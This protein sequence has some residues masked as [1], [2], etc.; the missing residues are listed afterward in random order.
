MTENKDKIVLQRI[1]EAIEQLENKQ[2]NFYFFVSDCKNTPNSNTLYIYQM[3]LTLKER[4]YN[5]TMLYQL[6]NEYTPNELKQLKQ[7][8]KPIDE[9]RVFTGVGEWLGEKY[10]KLPHLNIASGKWRVS[11]ADF[12]FI[13]EVFSS[14]MKETFDKSIPCKRYVI[15]Q[16]FKYVTEFIPFGDQWA[17]YGITD[18]IATTDTL[19]EQIKTVFPYVKT[20]VL[21]PFISSFIRKP[22]TAKKLIVNIAAPR[23][24]EI[25]HIIKTFYWR[26]PTLQFVTYADMLRE[27][28]ITVWYD[29]ESPFGYSG[30][31]AIR[32]GNILIGKIPET[33]PEWMLNEDKLLDNGIWYNNIDEIPDILAKVV[34][35]WMRDE[36]PEELTNAME[37]TNKKYTNEKWNEDVETMMNTIISDRKVEFLS[38]KTTIENKIKNEEEK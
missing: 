6:N 22:L 24:S 1:E 18:A 28:C 3:A 27:G 31:D 36:I 37:E 38:I 12:L 25:E 7:K 14:L 23:E 21:N 29:P 19:A 16:N 8:E 15:L 11:P 17:S 10:A 5:V 4:G 35:S 9:F 33:V 26:Y 2:T 34:G 13:P 32:S 30:L 20:I